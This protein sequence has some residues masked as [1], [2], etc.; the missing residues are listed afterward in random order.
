MRFSNL[1]GAALLAVTLSACGGR[2]PV[3]TD[4]TKPATSDTPVTKPNQPQAPYQQPGQ[5]AGQ[6]AVTSLLREVQTAFAAMPGYRADLETIDAKGGHRAVVKSKAVFSKPE[7][8]RVEI[9][10]NT[11][12]ASQAGTKA[13][14]RGASQMEVRPSGILKFAKVNIPTSDSR[15]KTLNGYR[16]DQISLRAAMN[17]LFSTKAQVKILGNAQLGS[18]AITLVDVTGATMVPDSDHTR[19]GIDSLTKLPV[20]VDIM[21]GTTSTYTVH[22]INM[23]VSKVNESEL[24]I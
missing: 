1:I 22:L 2:S 17:T 8:L 15:I 21:N 13:L 23:T 5:G 4:L 14:W 16:V 19:I 9:L 7:I 20:S 11:D 10:S 3:S 18:R 12:Q 6:Q 24:A